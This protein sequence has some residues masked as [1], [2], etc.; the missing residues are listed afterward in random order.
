M[1][2]QNITMVLGWSWTNLSKSLNRLSLRF[3]LSWIVVI[4]VMGS[5]YD[6][7]HFT[8]MNH[9]AVLNCTVPSHL[10]HC[11]GPIRFHLL[12]LNIEYSCI[13]VL[14]YEHN[15]ET[16]YET[17]AINVI[18]YFSPGIVMLGLFIGNVGY[19]V[20]VDPTFKVDTV[21]LPAFILVEGIHWIHLQHLFF[22]CSMLLC[23]GWL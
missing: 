2:V 17:C 5:C 11:Y 22:I 12:H 15:F 19:V 9:F 8:L 7:T 23:S 10:M 13:L 6:C 3:G 20:Y 1:Y 16:L 4:V 14:P 21:M 18:T